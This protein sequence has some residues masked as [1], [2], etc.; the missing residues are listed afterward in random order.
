MNIYNL[1]KIQYWLAGGATVIIIFG[2]IYLHVLTHKQ[3]PYFVGSFSSRVNLYDETFTSAV[4]NISNFVP[5]N[6]T[7]VVT[8]SSGVIKYFTG[9]PVKIPWR[10]NSQERLVQYMTDNNFTYL[11]VPVI[12]GNGSSVETLKPLFT[13]EGLRRLTFDFQRLAEFETEFSRIYLYKKFS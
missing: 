1:K 10:V 13:E 7:L 2:V 11:V 5:K 6:E 9:H 3:L 4:R 12:R 8:S